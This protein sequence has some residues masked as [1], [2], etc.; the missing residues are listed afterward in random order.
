MALIAAIRICILHELITLL[1][2]RVV[3]QMGKLVCLDVCGVVLLTRKPRKA[4]IVDVNPPGVH[5]CYANVKPHI[6]LEA[7]NEKWVVQISTHN[8]RLINGNF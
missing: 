2:D 8:V 7:V 1:I 6:E 5:R 4:L 3:G